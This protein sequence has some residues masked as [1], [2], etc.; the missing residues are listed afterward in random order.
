MITVLSRENLQRTAVI[1]VALVAIGWNIW[2]AGMV[3]G[4]IDPVRKLGAQDEAVYAREAIHM[5]LYGNWPT[6][7]FLDRFVLFKPPMLMWLSAISAKL[8]GIGS[9]G[10][11][12]PAILAGVAICFFA[13]WR[14][15]PGEGARS[16]GASRSALGFFAAPPPARLSTRA[17]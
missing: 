3:T 14:A 7:T 4:Y 15:L 8:F 9:F 12:L 10:L 5:A 11:R 13:W 1:L 17:L 6:Q 2:N 16:C